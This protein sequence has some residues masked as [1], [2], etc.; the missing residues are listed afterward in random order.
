MKLDRV[1]VF[2]SSANKGDKGVTPARLDI[3]DEGQR[4]KGEYA[5]YSLAKIHFDEHRPR[6]LPPNRVIES[7]ECSYLVRM[8]NHES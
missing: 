5:G 2:I 1:M 3:G 6:L 8:I 7:F 4:G